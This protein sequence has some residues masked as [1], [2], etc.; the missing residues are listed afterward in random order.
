[1]PLSSRR[2]E[3]AL[4]FV[5]HLRQESARFRAVLAEADPALRVPTC[6]DWRVDDLLWHLGEV[7]WFWG[8]IAQRRATS[9]S[10]VERL[11]AAK[12]PRPVD[13]SGLLDLFDHSS[14]RLARVLAATPPETELWMWAEDHSAAYI[15]RRQAH[16]ALIHRIDAELTV[17]AERAPVD[18]R[19][20]AD[21]VDE[22]LRVMRGY[23]PEPGLS[24]TPTGPP[25]TIALVDG[26]HTWTVTPARVTGTDSDGDTWDVQRLLGQDESASGSAA[27]SGR[28]ADLDCWLWNRPAVGEISRTG[29]PAALQA[30]EAVVAGS[31]D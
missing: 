24:A 25:V 19:L 13:R 9:D 5:D 3:G 16:E 23:E 11:E 17:G 8:E 10:D 7:Q 28:A 4:P 6:P 30:L 20:A 18:C 26:F 27:V 22:A 12:H 15:A 2:H 21:G 14:E 1:M 31:I 29:D